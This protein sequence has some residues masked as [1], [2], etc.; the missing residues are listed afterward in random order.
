MPVHVEHLEHVTRSLECLEFL[1][2]FA[3]RPNDGDSGPL[4]C[5]IDITAKFE[6]GQ[7]LLD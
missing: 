2:D 5:G 3:K 4:V 7:L 6:F 1:R